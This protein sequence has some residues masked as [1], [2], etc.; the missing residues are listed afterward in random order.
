MTGQEP[1]NV[2]FP[3]RRWFH[4]RVTGGAALATGT[5]LRVPP[6]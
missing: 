4:D 6:G 1:G 2:A 3:P 5:P